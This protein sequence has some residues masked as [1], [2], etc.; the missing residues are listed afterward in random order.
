MKYEEKKYKKN[1]F[2]FFKKKNL[3][4]I[5]FFTDTVKKISKIYNCATSARK[6]NFI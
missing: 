1:L 2:F 6:H 4:N 3:K 5:I